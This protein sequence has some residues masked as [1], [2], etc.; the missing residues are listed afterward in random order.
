MVG[1][2]LIAG[3]FVVAEEVWLLADNMGPAQALATVAIVAATGYGALYGADDDR[4][5]DRE[6]ASPCGSS[7]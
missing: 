4:D 5:P 2:F 1:G 3:P 7:R 6:A